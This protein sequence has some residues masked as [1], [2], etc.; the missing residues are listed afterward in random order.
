MNN[1]ILF[2]RRATAGKVDFRPNREPGS[3]SEQAR[4]LESYLAANEPHI[5]SDD[6]LTDCPDALNALREY[7]YRKIFTGTSHDDFQQLDVR[8]PEHIDW[9][10]RV[11]EIESANHQATR[12]R[13]PR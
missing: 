10:I 8:D 12:N 4:R 9:A 5:F 3:P 6:D 11:H 2:S 1:S 13:N 7:Q